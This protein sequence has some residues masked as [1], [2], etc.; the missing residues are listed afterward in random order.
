LRNLLQRFPSVYL[1]PARAS[2]SN[3]QR[4]QVRCVG[5]AKRAM[6]AGDAN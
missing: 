1:S 6:L 2:Q 4:R 3:S 5:P